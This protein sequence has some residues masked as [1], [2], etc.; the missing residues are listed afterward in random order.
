MVRG[1]V[2]LRAS[3]GYPFVS[4]LAYSLSLQFSMNLRISLLLAALTLCAGCTTTPWPLRM[5]QRPERT[6]YRTAE[7]R[8]DAVRDMRSKATGADSPDQREIANQLARQIQVEPD[9]LVRVTIVDT[10]SEFKTP[11]ASQVLEAGLSD[12][13]MQ[14]R[15]HCC[16]ALGRRKDPA[17]VPVLAKTINTEQKLE[18]RVAA[19]NAL[20]EINSPDAY[21][22]LAVAMEDRDPAMQFAG[23]N[24]MKAISGKDLGG[25]VSA[26]LQFARG[27]NPNPTER[28]I[29]VAERIG[30]L[31][32]FK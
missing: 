2:A 5:L 15:R 13:D 9:P 6:T 31:N 3:P 17:A 23:V 30:G 1:R 27:E 11:L 21:A 22:A 20:G 16:L 18:V 10:L 29:S 32:P 12:E 24:S 8:M 19:V 14:V 7:M 25:D 26:W 28:E 4:S